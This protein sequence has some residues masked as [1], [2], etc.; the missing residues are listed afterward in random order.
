MPRPEGE[1]ATIPDE[2]VLRWASGI[3]AKFYGKYCLFLVLLAIMALF[4]FDN[5]AWASTR[6]ERMKIGG[7]FS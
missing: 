2:G 7:M 3:S 6:V 5:P 1:V 4:T